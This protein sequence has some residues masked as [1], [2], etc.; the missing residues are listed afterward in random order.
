MQFNLDHIM[1]FK[2]ANGLLRPRF[3][4]RQSR[5]P[6]ALG[7]ISL[8]AATLAPS[9]G[10]SCACGCGVFDVGTSSMFPEGAG[11]MFFIDYD[12]Q[13]QNRNWSG[14][15]RAPAQNNSD[16]EI[17]THFVTAGLQYLFN[18]DWGIQVE[19][20]YE[21]RYF[22]TGDGNDITSL[23]WG[24][25]GDIRVQGIYTGF[26]EDLSTGITFGLKLPT[27][28]YTYNDA[29]GDVDRD[30]EIGTGSTDLLLGA[31]HRGKLTRDNKWT[32][33]AQAQLDLP[34]LTRDEYRPGLEVDGALGIYYSGWSIGRLNIT[35]VA[36]VI[37]SERTSDTGA[38][39]AG[40]A[41]D[42][43]AGGV[44]SG[45]QRVLL[46]PGIEFQIHPVSIYADV[47]IPVFEHVTG[48]QLVA[49]VLF[50]LIMSYHF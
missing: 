9:V 27:G 30:T 19:V 32:W 49:P 2:S 39:A 31:F 28:N 21:N 36:Q 4:G 34:M 42:D 25:L 33:F 22:K 29:A 1:K 48:N 6:A 12:Y 11:G 7:S 50:K 10:W 46:S 24:D 23:N 26:S 8:M 16:K 37:G 44:A 47:E 14:D 43:P 5:I 40:G 17:R 38:E 35:P 13:D 18:R 3:A 15:S 45:Y 41:L 20:P